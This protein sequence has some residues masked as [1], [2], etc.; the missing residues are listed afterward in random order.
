MNGFL[1]DLRYAVRSLRKSQGF[2]VSAVLILASGIGA[3]VAIFSVADGVLLKPLPYANP[4]R[5]VSLSTRFSGDEFSGDEFGISQGQ[6]ITIEQHSGTIEKIGAFFSFEMT[7]TGRGLP[8]RVRVARATPSV[9]SVLGVTPVL[10]RAMTEE[11]VGQKTDVA[12]LTH[13]TWLRRFGG[14]PNVVGQTL[15]LNGV[16]RTIVGVLP[17]GLQMPRDAIE[18][19]E[20]EVWLPPRINRAQPNWGSHALSGVA[21]LAPGQTVDRARAEMEV[22]QQ[23]IRR[24]HLAVVPDHVEVVLQVRPV[25]D[26]LL[27]NAKGALRLLIAAVALVLLIAVA[28][29]AGLLLIRSKTREPEVAIRAALGAGRWPVIRQLLAESVVL[30]GLGTALGIW[31]AHGVIRLLPYL[32]VNRLPRLENV[33]LDG[34][35]MLFAVAVQ[36][37]VTIVFGAISALYLVRADLFS[38][39]R[40]GVRASSLARV[41][42][43]LVIGQVAATMTLLL[44]AGLMLRSFSEILQIDPGFD[45]E[46]TLTARVS[47]TP[48]TATSPTARSPQDAATEFYA[49]ILQSVGRI[50]GVTGAA[51]VSVVPLSGQSGDTVF[52]IEGRLPATNDEQAFQH[53]TQRWVTPEYFRVMGIPIIR[54]RAFLDTDRADAP[55]VIIINQRFAER[56]WPNENPI[57]RR[58]RMYWDAKKTGPWLEIVGVVG[59][60]KQLTMTGDVDAEMI[61]PFAQTRTNSG[62][63]GMTSMTLVVR[64]SGDSM[65]LVEPIRKA[66]A[67][68]DPTAPLHNVQTMQHAVAQ[69]IAQPR[70]A[71][72]LVSVFA[73]IALGLAFVGLY[74]VVAYA[75]ALRTREF[76]TR[77]ALGAT[78]KSLMGL[79]LRQGLRLAAFG[80]LIGFAAAQVVSNALRSYL[81]GITPTDPVTIMSVVGVLTVALLLASYIPARRAACVDPIV[82]LR[83]E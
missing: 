5:L 24:D 54:G 72:T 46:N 61:H 53:A 16:A 50:P 59:N 63:N 77:V 65:A 68:L 19:G 47:P 79:V 36:G 71:V 6:F 81:Y 30:V 28:N 69:S 25:L 8:E 34:R 48:S 58:M 83:Y 14:D 17:A 4:D 45:P 15:I 74:S 10:G 38:A 9:F 21:L 35:T 40:L 1:Q 41:R 23:R 13:A 2:A 31:I 76:G 57:G 43:V 82:A 67:T 75:V 39:L 73:L 22:F 78:D 56:H 66:V 33:T 62:I 80:A 49:D 11:D 52:D 51:A 42:D 26:D 64:T 32:A 12:L 27:G 29:L 20:V 55:G 60:S 70:V 7:L 44:G 3:A 18:P 37:V